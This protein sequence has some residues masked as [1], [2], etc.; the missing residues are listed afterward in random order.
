MNSGIPG[1]IQDNCEKFADQNF[2][3]DHAGR[4]ISYYQFWQGVSFAA[5]HLRKMGIGKQSRFSIALPNCAEYL[6]LLFGGIAEKGIAVNLNPHMSSE[7][8]DYRF[9][10]AGVDVLFTTQD[11]AKRLHGIL[12]IR[13]I[14]CVVIKGG[15]D[16]LQVMPEHVDDVEFLDLTTFS[17]GALL[18][19]NDDSDV[20]EQ[21]SF[22]QYTGGTTGTIKA[23]M[24]SQNNVLSSV[25]QMSGYLSD[26]LCEGEETF[27]VTFP[28]YHVFS[29]VFQVLT[30]MKFGSKIIIYPNTRDLPVL[31]SLMQ[32]IPF[33]VFVGVHTLYK[34]ML[35]DPVL[36]T[37]RYPSAKIFI[38]GAEHIQPSTKSDWLSGTGHLIVEG[39]GLTETSALAT[40][41]LLDPKMN[42]I[43]SIGCPLPNTEIALM[44]K[45]DELIT[46]A[47]VQGEIWIRGP[48]VVKSY[49]N[50]PTDNA[51]TF[52]DGW[53]R[54][55]DMAE[56][57]ANG[58]Y[59]IVGRKKDMI[60][61]S[62]FNV[63]PSE[64]ESVL[65]QYSGIIEC[66]VT[67]VANER[68]GERVAAFV[69]TNSEENE[70]DI[71]RF[72]SS[73]LSAYKVPVS[74]RFMDNLPKSAV[75]KTLRRELRAL[76]E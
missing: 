48:Q 74:V 42:D 30:A 38:A 70:D 51:S 54:T 20:L 56:L 18:S 9:M 19:I 60:N 5:A 34:W 7:E 68:S 65:M 57:K 14:R 27:M 45:S 41:S 23:A 28:F 53:L 67:G 44:N 17:D 31:S 40:M 35:Q 43:D 13:G 49:W 61:V 25:E 47:G 62:G 66:A 29:I 22:F 69:I 75:G 37:L 3:T 4:N 50:N 1:F 36:S 2:I 52:V 11:T 32:R 46:E 76:L 26:R 10:N 39:Y 33:T 73:R 55:G 71:I 16:D 15:I 21:V 8:F 12:N 24:I 6:Y 64:V 63:Y 59:R 58:Q 72:C